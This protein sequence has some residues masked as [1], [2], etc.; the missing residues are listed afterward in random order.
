MILIYSAKTDASTNDVLDWLYYLKADSNLLYRFNGEIG[1]QD[2]TV[3]LSNDATIINYDNKAINVDKNSYWYR[4][5]YFSLKYKGTLPYNDSLLIALAEE[6]QSLLSLLNFELRKGNYINLASD[7]DTS[8]ILNLRLATFANLKIPE[9]LVTNKMEEVS[10]FFAKHKR[11]ITKSICNFKAELRVGGQSSFVNISGTTKIVTQSHIDSLDNKSRNYLPSLFQEY[12]EKAFELRIFYLVGRFY[13]MAIFSQ[14]NDKTKIDFR[15]YDEELP[16]RC[17]PYLLPESIEYK[18]TTFM[19]EIDM[20]CGSIDMI[21][22]PDNDYVF[23]EVNPIGQFQWVSNS[24]NYD[25]ER[26]IA[27]LLNDK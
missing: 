23:L 16:N 15:N 26:E 22:T 27:K 19:K 17:V 1:L 13:P 4:R 24:C 3:K 6:R 25:I 2:F 14:S 11:I 7:N 5:G 12:I 18:L 21:V 9:T 8:K 20:N 10:S